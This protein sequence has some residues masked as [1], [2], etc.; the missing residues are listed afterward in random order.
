M[1]DDAKFEKLPVYVKDEIRS[2]RQEISGLKLRNEWLENE[3]R[4]KVDASNTIVSEGLHDQTAL[5]NFS[6]V[7]FHL[8]SPT[9]RW[10]SAITVRVSR[11][12]QRV[13]IMGTD[14]LVINPKVSNHI[15]LSLQD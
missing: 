15:D 4:I 1:M 7:E 6:N 10:K 11:D 5:P 12:G 13:E 14:A 2:L 9:K 3:N 8:K